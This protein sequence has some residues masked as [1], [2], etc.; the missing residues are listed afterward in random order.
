MEKQ[1]THKKVKAQ[2]GKGARKQQRKQATLVACCRAGLAVPDLKGIH[3]GQSLPVTKE[4]E[5][6][7][8]RKLSQCEL[9]IY[10]FE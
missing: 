6:E 7:E 1:K 9:S 5:R 2:E 10:L 3:L 8:E 4:R